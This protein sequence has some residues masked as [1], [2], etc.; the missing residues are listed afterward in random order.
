MC[1]HLLID[2]T[3]RA[4]DLELARTR[5]RLNRFAEGREHRL[6]HI[7]HADDCRHAERDPYNGKSTSKSVRFQMRPGDNPQE[8]DQKRDRAAHSTR[9]N[10]APGVRTNRERRGSRRVSTPATARW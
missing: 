6:A 4:S 1:N 5:D 9:R 7:G 3:Y 2:T 10:V 8:M